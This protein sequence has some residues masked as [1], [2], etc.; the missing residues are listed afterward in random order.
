MDGYHE[1]SLIEMIEQIGEEKVKSILSDFCCKLNPDVEKFLRKQ[2]I[3]FAKQN[4]SPTYLVFA[5]YKNKLVLVGYYTITSKYFVIKDK[6]AISNNLR[7]RIS[8][9]GTRDNEL[10][11]YNISAPLLA[12]L[13]KNY[14]NGYNK[15]ITGDELLKMACDKIAFAQQV[16][17]GKVVYLECEEKEKLVDFYTSNGF[18]V[19]DKRPLDKDEVDLDGEYL[20]QLLRYG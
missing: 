2:A 14:K 10:G 20:L 12:Q 11:Q 4:L 18:V 15:L 6:C 9:F 13:G 8:K 5:P 17:G 3:T 16:V 7:K 19:F 1:V